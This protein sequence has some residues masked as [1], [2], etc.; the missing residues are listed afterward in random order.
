MRNYKVYFEIYGK[1]MITTVLAET[2]DKA[3][4][5]V[6][7]KLKIVKVEKAINDTFNTMADIFKM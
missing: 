4:T 5:I 2:P 7:S 3:K 6:I 1:K